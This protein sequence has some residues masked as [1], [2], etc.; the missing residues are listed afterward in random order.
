MFEF[1]FARRDLTEDGVED[2]ELRLGQARR[3]QQPGYEAF[4]LFHI[5]Q[6]EQST[7]RQRRITQPAIAVI[8]I[9]VCT[10]SLRQRSCGGRNDRSGRGIC[11]Q[12]ENKSA[13]RDGLPVRAL[14]L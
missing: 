7:H 4:G 1:L 12:F 9:Q 14:V 3:M 5:S 6:S 11:K 8:P 13:A 2:P 10:Y